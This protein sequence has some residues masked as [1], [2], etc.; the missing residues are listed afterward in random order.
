MLSMSTD[1]EDLDNHCWSRYI[2]CNGFMRIVQLNLSEP[3][4]IRT[5]RLVIA[6]VTQE[7]LLVQ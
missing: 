2:L 1:D 5:E 3:L 7:R 6:H 4:L